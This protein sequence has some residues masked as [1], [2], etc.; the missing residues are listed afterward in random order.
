[1]RS[2]EPPRRILM[3]PGPSDVSPRV[4]ASLARPTIGHLDPAFQG[5]MEEIKA[6]LADV[7]NAPGY[8]CVPLPAPGTGAMEAALMNLLEPD[9]VA[10]VAV[11]GQFGER[12]VQMAERAGAK[13]VR[14][15]H[16]WGQPV[17]AGRVEA[18]LK[19]N[20]AKVLAFVHAETSTG[21]KSD[22]KA[23]CAVARA[24]GALTVVD[25]VTSLGG[26]EVDVA[27][28][29]ADAVYSGTQKC[30]SAPPGLAPFA[31]SPRAL[32]AIS[33]RK[34][35][36][37]TWLFDV[38][39]LMGYWSGE[40]GRTYHHTAP[41]NALYGLHEALVV[42]QEEGL[43][44]AIARHRRVHEAFA[45]GIEAAGLSFLVDAAHRLPELNAVR[46][47]DGIDEAAVRAR[48]LARYDL[49]IG[50][51]LGPLR[52]KIWRI[53]LMGAS[54]TPWHVRLCLTALTEAL[55]AQNYPDVSRVALAA[56]D[57]KLG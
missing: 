27:G 38:S 17:D 23:I 42:L 43:E 26:I 18:A 49:E 31:L 10:V 37:R 8:A 19:A 40:G 22:A 30:L 14:V 25:C 44:A 3:G 41:I 47:P 21:A 12:M 45:A 1:M 5:L 15:D 36:V 56:A 29:D 32:A 4:L 39:L 7:M 11:N 51:G 57:A 2:F 16:D 52:G 35:P 6:A 28:W 48:M 55:A 20:S 33:A 34:T 53:G 9:D 50:A 24:H 13:V 54:A 46:I